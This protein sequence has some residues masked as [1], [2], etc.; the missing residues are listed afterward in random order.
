MPWAEPNSSMPDAVQRLVS[1]SPIPYATQPFAQPSIPF[2]AFVTPTYQAPQM[3]TQLPDY[4]GMMQSMLGMMQPQR[5]M[6][7][8]QMTQMSPNAAPQKG[9]E[10]VPP[11]FET[12]DQG[13]TRKAPN[14]SNAYQQ[15]LLAQMNA[16]GPGRSFTQGISAAGIDYGTAPVRNVPVYGQQ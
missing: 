16:Q 14:T 4:A 8:Q 10:A 2:G 1:S 7:S 5:S 3:Q 12:T 6:Q 11:G 9:Q 15:Q 13:V